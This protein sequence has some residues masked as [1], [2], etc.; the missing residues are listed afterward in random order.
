MFLFLASSFNVELVYVILKGITQFSYLIQE[1][2]QRNSIRAGEKKSRMEL[3]YKDGN[4]TVVLNQIKIKDFDKWSRMKTDEEV[5]QLTKENLN[6][7]QRT[8]Q[9]SHDANVLKMNERVTITYHKM[10]LFMEMFP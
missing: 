4:V 8:E 10:D 2:T 9:I 1:R 6:D 5:Q 3:V 7:L